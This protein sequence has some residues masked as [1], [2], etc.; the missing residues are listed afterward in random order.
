MDKENEKLFKGGKVMKL[1]LEKKI[2][3]GM[4]VLIVLLFCLIFFLMC[5]TM[6]KFTVNKITENQT[7]IEVPTKTTTYSTPTLPTNKYDNY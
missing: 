5:S 6:A 2:S 7:R 1:D 3:S 4:L